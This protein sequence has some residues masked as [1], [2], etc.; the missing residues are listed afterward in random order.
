[1]IMLCILEHMIKRVYYVVLLLLYFISFRYSSPSIVN[2]N[3]NIIIIIKSMLTDDGEIY[4]V[5]IY[6]PY[7]RAN[8]GEYSI[9]RRL[10]SSSSVCFI[11]ISISV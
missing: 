10:R 2:N 5:D 7:R 11:I 1:M 8:D 3:I 9:Y 4:N 6:I